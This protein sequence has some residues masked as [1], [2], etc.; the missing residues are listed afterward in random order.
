MALVWHAPSPGF[1]QYYP[2][3]YCLVDVYDF[4]L[5]IYEQD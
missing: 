2:V 1:P 4:C 5:Y 3:V